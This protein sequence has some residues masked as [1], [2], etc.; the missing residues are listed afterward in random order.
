MHPHTFSTNDA[1]LLR[2]IS[3]K[4]MLISIFTL[5]A[6][7]VVFSLS[8][9]P[10]YY[11]T[12]F[13]NE[14]R[15]ERYLGEDI[16]LETP[17]QRCIEN[18]YSSY[19]RLDPSQGEIRLVEVA[20]GRPGEEI[21]IR[22]GKYGGPWTKGELDYTA[23][24]YCWGDLQQTRE[25]TML[26]V[27]ITP[28]GKPAPF[29]R[30]DIV[31]FNVTTN[32]YE[33]LERVRHN[34]D[35]CQDSGFWSERLWIDALSINQN[36]I[37]E[38]SEQVALIGDRYSEA[39]DVQI[40]LNSG[41]VPTYLG[42][43]ISGIA[44]EVRPRIQA[45]TDFSGHV[46][47]VC[48]LLGRISLSSIETGKTVEE[49]E[50]LEALANLFDSP[51]FRRVWVLQ[52]VLKAPKGA[53]HARLS[54]DTSARW[55]DLMLAYNYY[56]RA[57]TS[58][59]KDNGPQP[60]SHIPRL[61]G[62]ALAIRERK[63]GAEGGMTKLDS[64]GYMS[65]LELFRRTTTHFHSTD[66]RDKLYAILSLSDLASASE[67]PITPDYSLS[68]SQVYAR[69]TKACIRYYGNL[70]A[71]SLLHET[72]TS[73]HLSCN[74]PHCSKIH[75]RGAL[76]DGSD[77]IHPS[78]AIWPQ[79]K[80]YWISSSLLAHDSTFRAAGDTVIDDQLFEPPH[81]SASGSS[82]ASATATNTFLLPLRGVPL[83]PIDLVFSSP[84]IGGDR[85]NG[86]WTV[87][88]LDAARSTDAKSALKLSELWTAV[89]TQYRARAAHHGTACAGVESSCRF[90][91][92]SADEDLFEAFVETMLCRRAAGRERAAGSP[93]WAAEE[94]GE[95]EE[96]SAGGSAAS[97]AR[98]W[99]HPDVADKLA[100]HWVHTGGDPEMETLPGAVREEL[101]YLP[102]LQRQSKRE[103]EGLAEEFAK[104]VEPASG[105]TLFITRRG[106]LG[107]CP[108]G[109]RPGDRPVI[110][111]G[112]KVPFILRKMETVTSED[113]MGGSVDEWKLIGECYIHGA[114]DGSRFEETIKDGT[115]STVF[116]LK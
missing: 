44:N 38:R 80:K 37:Q 60:Y 88:G 74:C 81:H 43:F 14:I 33:L 11:P 107:L 63:H 46:H 39:K 41:H 34:P 6:N 108:I 28:D 61:W 71:L 96:E 79:S 5:L 12:L 19:R 91:R 25:I 50:I 26:Q 30:A 65:I 42:P 18:N 75:G 53:V 85:I 17:T 56:W 98:I 45:D 13:P 110:L 51:W 1:F 36:D 3:W 66:P 24:S 10:D 106:A 15:A 100:A 105:R 69:F 7:V 94:E 73:P 32:L 93:G 54:H 47:E 22:L 67:P 112:G 16:S 89:R 76:V 68:T 86:T 62:E 64:G 58:R 83:E 82:S 35:E 70:D 27:D 72:T 101:E 97:P 23:V 78:W 95:E 31:R 9:S 92:A 48:E 116:Y 115:E 8:A 77:T 84:V 55:E 4:A 109:T 99:Q 87:C 57:S 114:M 90:D 2:G 29:A 49:D 104:M 59:R 21:F 111:L 102:V 113:A 52:E 103:V 20:P 40:F